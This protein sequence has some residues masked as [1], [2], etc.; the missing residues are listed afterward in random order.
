MD[1]LYKEKRGGHF[2]RMR[3]EKRKLWL[4]FYMEEW[5]ELGLK[6]IS[7]VDMDLISAA[8]LLCVIKDFKYRKLANVYIRNLIKEEF[9]RRDMFIKGL[10][11]DMIYVRAE[12]AILLIKKLPNVKYGKEVA[13]AL[14]TYFEMDK[15]RFMAMFED[16]GMKEPYEY[17]E[18][19]NRVLDF[20]SVNNGKKVRY[21]EKEEIVVV[22]LYDFIGA[23]CNK[24][25][26]ASVNMWKKIVRNLPT[27][28]GDECSNYMFNGRLNKYTRRVISTYGAVELISVLFR[29]K[30]F[31]GLLTKV[32]GIFCLVDGAMALANAEAEANANSN[33]EATASTTENANAKTTAS[34]EVRAN[35]VRA[36]ANGVRAKVH[37]VRAKVNDVR[38]RVN[39]VRTKVN[40]V[41]AK[42]NALTQLNVAQKVPASVLNMEQQNRIYYEEQRRNM[43]PR[44]RDMGIMLN[45]ILE[46]QNAVFNQSPY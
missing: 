13:N 26:A 23:V 42:A 19:L 12:D 37:A 31:S 30:D 27:Y 18:D 22:G 7:V 16:N 36:K 29:G 39:E 25:F 4:E 21:A 24:D 40:G 46:A 33:A 2:D 14:C 8:D 5:R 44:Q 3:R 6:Y 17:D 20:H 9:V 15:S 35:A 38:A 1:E 28:I 10:Q 11:T 41:G 45:C 43:T 32:K 34:V